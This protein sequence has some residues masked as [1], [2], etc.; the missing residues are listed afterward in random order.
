MAAQRLK[1]DN[2][3]AEDGPKKARLEFR[4]TIT[5]KALIERAA[6]LLGE[7][8]TSFVL[9]TALRDA[10]KV[11]Q[12]HQITELSLRDWLRFEAILDAD[13]A[14]TRHLTDAMKRYRE[15]VAQ[16]SGL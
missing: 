7:S 15:Q 10:V 8:L 5:Q 13:E 1:S 16:S 9:S 4:S 2:S 3:S 14:P 11:I 12:D 6:S